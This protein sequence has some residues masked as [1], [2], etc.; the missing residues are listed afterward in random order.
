MSREG[1]ILITLIIYK[2]FLVGIGIG[3][4]NAFNQAKISLSEAIHLVLRLRPL[5]HQQVLFQP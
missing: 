5:V 4:V 1:V 2:L 3:L